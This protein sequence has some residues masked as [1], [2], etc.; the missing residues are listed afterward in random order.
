MTNRIRHILVQDGRLDPAAAEVYVA[1]YPER[2]TSTTQVRG[3][4]TGP[5]CA[6]AS[7]VEVAYPLRE[8]E[9]EYESEGTPHVTLRVIIPEASLWDPESPFLYEGPLELWQGGQRVGELQL[10]HGLRWANLGPRGLRWN[11]R[12]LTVRGATREQLSP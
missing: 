12:L 4:L 2:L 1:V 11:G 3:R 5:R 10:R 7:T 9:R 6:Y 8:H